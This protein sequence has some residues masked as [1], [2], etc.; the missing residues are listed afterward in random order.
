MKSFLTNRPSGPEPSKAAA[1]KSDGSSGLLALAGL[2]A[3]PIT[4][5]GANAGSVVTCRRDGDIVRTII[6]TC[7]CGKVTE[8]DCHY[9]S[10]G[11]SR[12]AE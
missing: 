4:C 7:A 9:N 12:P 2:Q 6:V 3:Q 11:G 8:I 10:E 5:D 1:F